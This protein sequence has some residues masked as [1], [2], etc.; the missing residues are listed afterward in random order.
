MK[1]NENSILK[2]QPEIR[3]DIRQ[4]NCPDIR[5][6]QYPVQP[7]SIYRLANSD[8]ASVFHGVLL[9]GGLGSISVHNTQFT[10]VLH[11]IAANAGNQYPVILFF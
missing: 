7:Y 2:L 1:T 8:I 3:P 5:P 10:D 11:P 9:E 4:K 6:I